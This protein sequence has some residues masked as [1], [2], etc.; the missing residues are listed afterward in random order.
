M[1]NRWLPVGVL[2]TVGAGA[3]HAQSGVAA[4]CSA[5][6]VEVQDVCQK[7]VDLFNYMAPQLGTAIA[8]GNA[9]LGQASVLGG[10]G[11]FSIGLRVNAVLGAVPDFESNT[12]D[13]ISTTGA[14]R[15]QIATMDAPI[16]MPVV[17]AAVG[18]FKGFPVGLTHVGGV[19]ALVSAFYVP[20]YDDDGVTLD[21]PDGSLKFGYGARLGL[22]REAGAVPAVSLTYLVRELPTLS[23]T[24]LVDEEN[25]AS[26]GLREFNLKTTS[27]RIV[28]GKH[29]GF[30]GLA[31]GA[32]QDTYETGAQVLAKL[33]AAEASP[34]GFEQKLT[35]TNIF[36]DVN[37]K[38][39]Q[40]EIGQVSGG[41][42]IGTYNSF[43]PSAAGES[44][45]YGSV[46]F[47]IGF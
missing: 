20:K 19:D 47:R 2:L 17:D 4:R 3:A 14:V 45:T 13:D 24:G 32:G 1:R 18:L 9:T 33:G 16:P 38:I 46:G 40:L 15:S 30:L 39:I 36:A 25:A 31:V 29:F 11:H 7:A 28:V 5:Q 23:I 42:A 10:L 41:D 34:F 8:G 12:Q 27:T 43:S 22:L 21:T 37:F 44:Y 6:Q 26:A 35:R